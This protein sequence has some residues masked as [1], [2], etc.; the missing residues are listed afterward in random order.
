MTTIFNK[1]TNKVDVVSSQEVTGTKPLVQ[2]VQVIPKA[3][4]K[5]ASKR[6]TE[7]K[8]VMSTIE[9]S[10]ESSVTF[11]SITVKD[12]KDVKIIT[13]IITTPSQPGK[14]EFVFVYDK[15]TKEVVEIESVKIEEEIKQVYFEKE[16]TKHNEVI[17]KSND[18]V[19]IEKE[20]PEINVVL[21]QI[22]ETY[23]EKISETVKS[24]K[25][26]EQEFSTEYQ[27]VTEVQGKIN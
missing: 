10:V 19:E 3:I 15:K 4:V 26:V 17:I 1:K 14:T 18:I 23:Q 5:I 25:V 13:P 2:H 27:I 20:R 21:T 9:T 16:V 22:D 12:L 24:V 8:E 6:F 7:I 11:E